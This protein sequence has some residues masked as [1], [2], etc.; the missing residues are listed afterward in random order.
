[1]MM[2][3]A[4]LEISQRHLVKEVEARQRAEAE[5]DEMRTVDYV[6]RIRA[7]LDEVEQKHMAEVEAHA[8]TQAVL[9]RYLGDGARAVFE[10]M[11][12]CCP[13]NGSEKTCVYCAVREVLK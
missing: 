1:V 9:R 6:A 11:F 2:A 12:C 4:K 13:P 5:R 10:Q 8:A 3:E 7:E